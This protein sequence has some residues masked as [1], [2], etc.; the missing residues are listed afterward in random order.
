MA[1]HRD[2][3]AGSVDAHEVRQSTP[4]GGVELGH[5]SAL[6]AQHDAVRRVLHVA[7][8]H[9][10]AVVGQRGGAHGVTG[11]GRVGASHHLDGGSLQLV[12]VLL[13]HAATMSYGGTSRFWQV[14]PKEG[15][16]VLCL[17]L[18]PEVAI[19]V[20]RGTGAGIIPPES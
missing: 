14:L 5:E 12:P 13:I 6:R 17:N 11:V 18:I 1:G 10:P 3:L 15:G 8:H 16:D 4:A 20:T 19:R 7:A 2:H 9:A